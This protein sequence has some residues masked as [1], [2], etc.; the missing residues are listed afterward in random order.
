MRPGADRSHDCKRNRA[1]RYL[2]Y[3]TSPIVAGVAKQLVLS[4]NCVALVKSS[5]EAQPVTKFGAV[6]AL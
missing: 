3:T 4:S 2:T 6:H 5:S 1:R